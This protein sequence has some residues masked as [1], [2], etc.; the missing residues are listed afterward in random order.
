VTVRGRWA[1]PHGRSHRRDSDPEAQEEVDEE[2]H[3]KSHD[4]I[5]LD[6][7]MRPQGAHLQGQLEELGLQSKGAE[8]RVGI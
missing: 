4:S 1:Q 7:M 2:L 5:R 8:C 6:G 3:R